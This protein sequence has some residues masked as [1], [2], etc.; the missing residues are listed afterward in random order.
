MVGEAPVVELLMQ[1][2]ASKDI[3]NSSGETVL[4]LVDDYDP[5]IQALLRRED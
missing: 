4:G 1:H 2:G 5:P 3:P